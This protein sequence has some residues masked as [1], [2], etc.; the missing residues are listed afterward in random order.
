MIYR[1]YVGCYILC[2][3][4]Y[5]YVGSTDSMFDVPVLCSLLYSLC[6]LLQPLCMMYMRYVGCSILYV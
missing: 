3:G 6:G 5:I 4:C 2:V 1:R